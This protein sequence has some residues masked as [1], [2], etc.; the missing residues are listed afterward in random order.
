MFSG[1]QKLG[2]QQD[3]AQD[4]DEGD[5]DFVS[6][7]LVAPDPG[8]PPQR[9]ENYDTELVQHQTLNGNGMSRI[10]APDRLGW[11]RKA[12]GVGFRTRAGGPR[13]DSARV[14]RPRFTQ[15]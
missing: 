2:E 14:M 10:V 12:Q 11:L 1:I 5:M 13:G 8:F 9:V 15:L 4:Q 3:E 7:R 6:A